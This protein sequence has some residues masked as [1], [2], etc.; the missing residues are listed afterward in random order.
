LHAVFEI[1][2]GLLR[3]Y[4][5][6]RVKYGV[7]VLTIVAWV[8][9]ISG[10]WF[11]YPGYRAPLPE[12]ANI[13]NYPKAYLLGNNLAFWHDFGM[14]WKEHVGWLVPMLATAVCFIVYRYAERL[15]EDAVMRKTVTALIAISFTASMVSGIFGAFISKV[16]PNNFLNL[17]FIGLHF[18]IS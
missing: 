16:A 13:L 18:L 1:A 14:E 10:T 9:V 11:V 17:S 15:R 2:M 3:N 4:E 12:G 8:T 5:P 6:K 7:L